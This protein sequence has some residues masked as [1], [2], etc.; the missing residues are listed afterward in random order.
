MDIMDQ[1]GFR[2]SH[3]HDL[4]ASMKPLF[5]LALILSTACVP[6]VCADGPMNTPQGLLVAHSYDRQLNTVNAQKAL[7][8]TK[9]DIW[10]QIESQF[11]YFR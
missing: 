5:I 2:F 6:T 8:I 9:S 11:K 3:A 7:L 4:Q 1:F 10:S